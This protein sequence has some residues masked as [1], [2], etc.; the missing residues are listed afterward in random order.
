MTLVS[1]IE[2]TQTTRCS[3]HTADRVPLSFPENSLIL[4]AARVISR[5][6]LVCSDAM[7]SVI[8][9][10]LSQESARVLK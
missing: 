4:S 6:I 10:S 5:L 8:A 1:L 3:I 7:A 9:R 2:Y